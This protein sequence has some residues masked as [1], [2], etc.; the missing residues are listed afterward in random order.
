MDRWCPRR[1]LL[2]T[3]ALSCLTA[4]AE[5]APE[6]EAFGADDAA[7]IRASLS[8]YMAANP[9]IDPDSFFTH[10]TDDVYWTYNGQDPW[11]GMEA[12]RAVNWCDTREAEITADR[13]E[14]SGELAYAYGT[15]S[16]E[17]E[18][19]SE[20]TGSAGMFLSVHRRGPDGVWR[21]AAMQQFGG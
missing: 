18:C 19:A 7:A 17:L 8:A 16:I 13:V 5:S 3:V 11:V 14:G 6:P 15:Y 20:P 21:I 2:L 4:C 9:N 10:F 1:A 12:L